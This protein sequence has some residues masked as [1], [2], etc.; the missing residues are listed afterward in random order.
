MGSER[1]IFLSTIAMEI[2]CLPTCRG[3]KM[4][5]VKNLR[6]NILDFTGHMVS[7]ATVQPCCCNIKAAL[8]DT[9]INECG[10]VPIKLYL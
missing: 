3:L 10:C 7:V 5:S 1:N 9:K 4:F 2:L 8:D 6:V